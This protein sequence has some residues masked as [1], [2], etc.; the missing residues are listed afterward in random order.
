MAQAT[1]DT[2]AKL[3]ELM[4]NQVVEQVM[5]DKMKAASSEKTNKKSDQSN[6]AKQEEKDDDDAIAAIREKRMADLKKKKSQQQEYLSLGHGSYDEI[7]QDEFLKT[8]TSSYRCVVHFYHN[9]F[10]RSKIFD[11]HLSKI[12]KSHLSAKF[13]KIDAEKAPFFTDRLNIRTLPTLC[14]FIDG[15]MKYQVVGFS[16]LGGDDFPTARLAR[17]LKTQEAITEPVGDYGDGPR[18]DDDDY[19]SDE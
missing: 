4:T 1:G 12:V 17:L 10:Q 16:T 5:K 3:A 2:N 13:V 6:A 7:K 19:E 9:D 18:R 15:I 14:V 11:A 8:V